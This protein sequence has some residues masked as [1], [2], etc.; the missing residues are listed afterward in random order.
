VEGGGDYCLPKGNDH[1]KRAEIKV[2]EGTPGYEISGVTPGQGHFYGGLEE[3][4]DRHRTFVGKTEPLQTERR[5]AEKR[6]QSTQCVRTGKT[7]AEGFKKQH[8]SKEGGREQSL[9]MGVF[10]P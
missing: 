5:A 10:S 2:G 1:Q 8:R 3:R 7:A 4:F 9:A 6:N